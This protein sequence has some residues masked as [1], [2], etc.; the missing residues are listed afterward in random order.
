MGPMWAIIHMGW[1][2]PSS[3]PPPQDPGFYLAPTLPSPFPPGHWAPNLMHSEHPSR[4]IVLQDRN[5]L[6]HILQDILIGTVELRIRK[7][8]HMFLGRLDPDPDLLERGM[9]PDPFIIKQK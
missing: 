2:F 4:A 9:D 1:P 6:Q 5:T 8:I 7:R 3:P